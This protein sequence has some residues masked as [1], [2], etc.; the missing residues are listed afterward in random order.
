MPD[1]TCAAPALTT[2][3]MCSSK[4]GLLTV[5][6]TLDTMINWED[7]ALIANYTDGSYLITDWSMESGGFWSQIEF[8]R[9][10]GRYNSEY[11]LANGFYDVLISN[12]LFKGHDTA[13]SISLGKAVA[14]CNLILQ[15]YDNNETARVV[16]R[17]FVSGAWVKPV[18]TA[19][20]ARHLDTSGVFGSE[21]DVS[22]D[23]FDISA[24]HA[25]PLPY[26]D[27]TILEMQAFSTP[28]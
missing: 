5:F 12:L 11:T 20:I 16:G 2:G 25:N 9:E 26:S 8:E 3:A 21:D 22:R 28:A 19:R 1:F 6:W 7:M 13:R 15:I 4:G 24:R 14:C 10:N 17:E 23:E 27:L 18:R